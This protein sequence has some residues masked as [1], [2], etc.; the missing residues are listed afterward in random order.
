MELIHLLRIWFIDRN[1]IIYWEF[2]L[3]KPILN[4]FFVLILTINT[5]SKVGVAILPLPTNGKILNSTLFANIGVYAKFIIYQNIGITTFDANSSDNGITILNCYLLTMLQS[6]QFLRSN[7][8]CFSLLYKMVISTC[9]TVDFTKIR[10]VFEKQN[11]QSNYKFFEMAKV[12]IIW[13]WL[14]LSQLVNTE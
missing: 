4:Y 1:I 6:K 7:Y 5:T 3:D 8:L 13:N 10:I 9:L 2:I 11:C 14:W 12:F